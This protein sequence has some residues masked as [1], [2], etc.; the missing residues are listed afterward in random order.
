VIEK[1]TTDTRSPLI[2]LGTFARQVR[3]STLK[4]LAQVHPEDRRWRPA[5]GTLSFADTLAHLI[6]V[7]RWVFDRLDGRCPPDIE[8]S[9]CAGD[10]IDWERSLAEFI[11]LGEDRAER[12]ARLSLGD[13][14]AVRPG[15][16]AGTDMPV[17]ELLLRRSLDHE[18]HHRG[19]LQLMLMIRYG[20]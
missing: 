5:A 20:A 19:E 12:T 17:W 8:P 15:G 4:R 2:W 14:T 1:M 18:I 10:A 11:R 9:T 13:L 6:E 16:P 3:Q 7:D